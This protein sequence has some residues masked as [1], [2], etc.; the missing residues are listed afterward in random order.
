MAKNDNGKP[1]K[2]GDPTERLITSDADKAKAAKWFARGRELGDK[3]QFDY[4]IEYYINGLEFWPDAV[5]EGCKPLHGCAVAR[6]QTGGK[7]PGFGDTMKRSL[8]DKNAKQALL[9][10]FWLFGRDPDKLGFVEGIVRNG[11]RVGAVQAAK[12]AG[13]I[14]FKALETNAKTTPKQLQ[15]LAQ[16]LESLGDCAAEQEDS[17]LAVSVYQ[18]GV[19]TLNVWYRR[20]PNDRAAETK[21]RNLS[22]K[23][24]ILKGKYQQNGSFRESMAD[25]EHQA[26]IHDKDRSVQSE[27]R[28][29]E[30]VA[31]A[32][33]AYRQNPD[34]ERALRELI[35]L[36]CRPEDDAGEKR[37]IGILVDKY[38]QSD[39]YSHKRMADE[40]RMKQLVR[41][42]RVA[43]KSG[44]QKAH[45]EHQVAS[46]RF[47][48]AVYKD[49]VQRYPT[50]N[51]FK[52]EYAVRLF[53]AGRFDDAI[54][55]FQAA[56]TNPRNRTACSMYLGRC[57]FRKDYHSQAIKT[58]QDEIA[59]YEFSDD[60]LAK[61]MLYWL[62]RAQEASGEIEAARDTYGRILQADYN[63]KDVRAKLDALAPPG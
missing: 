63:F 27:D 41:R 29:G 39:D 6:R 14:L 2:P 42:V 21:V 24:T 53:R 37:A 58:L 5:E 3:R 43:A 31:K 28:M 22:T 57:F 15:T 1:E 55:H 51:K 44:D 7:K 17:T 20:N 48:L 32:E 13:A 16:L 49:R 8:T 47:D 52:F 26:E 11:T 59:T 50:D 30:L 54:P 35:E 62:G 10:S 36:L 61:S 45:T 46:L 19:D 40:I 23:L 60:E 25:R 56:R 18:M 38:R 33:K 34:D 12:W 9:N 4:A